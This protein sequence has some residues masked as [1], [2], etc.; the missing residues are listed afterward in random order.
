MNSLV[1]TAALGAVAIAI[2]LSTDN[3]APIQGSGH[4]TLTTPAGEF[5][6]LGGTFVGPVPPGTTE[7]AMSSGGGGGQSTPPAQDITTAWQDQDGAEW[8]VHTVQGPNE[9]PKDFR[10]RHLDAVREM[11]QAAPP[12][13]KT[14]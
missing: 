5:A 6:D 1:V 7:E 2:G 12:K 3:P 14:P 8:N 9:D 11:K 13:A 10:K 4:S